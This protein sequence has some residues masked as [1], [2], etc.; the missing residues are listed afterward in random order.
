VRDGQTSTLRPRLVVFRS[1]CPPLS[2]SPHANSFVIGTAVINTH[3]DE[4]LQKKLPAKYRPCLA[5]IVGE[6]GGN[7]DDDLHPG[8]AIIPMEEEEVH[9]QL[10]YRGMRIKS[11]KFK[12]HHT[13]TTEDTVRPLMERVVRKRPQT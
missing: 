5:C 9:I 1:T 8:S 11:S 3:T 13:H 4:Y 2:P 10:Y 7:H 6:S 12:V